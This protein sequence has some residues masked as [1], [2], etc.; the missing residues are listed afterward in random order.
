MAENVQQ[1]VVQ[2]RKVEAIKLLHHN[3]GMGLNE[4]KNYVDRLALEYSLRDILH[5]IPI[6]ELSQ[7]QIEATIRE[8]VTLGRNVEA[9]QLMHLT[10][11]MSMNEAYEHIEMLSS[12]HD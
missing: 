9:M 8:L 3:T 5:N 12:M 2:D 6:Q 11:G 4:A 7:P 1:L 10:A